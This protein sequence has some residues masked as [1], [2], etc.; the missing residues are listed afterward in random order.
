MRQA[1]VISME[2][3]NKLWERGILGEDTPDKLRS[4]VLF[5]IG[6]N[7]AL[8]AGDE[9][10][11]LRRPGGCTSSQFSFECNEF[12][13]KCLVY[14]E[15]TITKTNRGGL[16]D[17]KKER[18][19]VWIKGNSD[20]RRCP[21]RLVEKY[22][23][24][25]PIEGSKPN[26]Y[27]QSLRKPRPNC[28]YSTTPVGIN[29]ICGV[30]ASILKDGGLN[31]YFTNHSLR[32]TCATRLFQAGENVKIVKE[33]TGHISDAVHKYQQTSDQQRMKASSIIQGDVPPVLLSQAKAMEVV[34][35]PKEVNLE[36]KFK[37]PKFELP[38][39]TSI[40]SEEG[41]SCSKNVSEIVEGVIRAVGNRKVKL[42]IEL[43]F[44]E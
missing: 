28:W 8:R 31:G 19:V 39:K 41:A 30:V 23:S 25:V 1:E 18:K 35:S 37:L 22:L 14:R 12:G 33:F 40:V 26:F 34:E 24:L 42:K 5:L 6:I 9:H 20:F 7:C 43:E 32:R 3:E 44:V 36:E 21:V 38:C 10:Y 15:D 13:L 29:K 2:Y 4:T 11:A 27:V 16:K 17:M